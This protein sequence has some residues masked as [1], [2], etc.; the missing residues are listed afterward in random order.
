MNGLPKVAAGSHIS[1]VL[2]PQCMSC[3]TAA[4]NRLGRAFIRRGIVDFV[5]QRPKRVA[6]EDL[7]TDGE[8]FGV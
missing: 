6:F 7:F 5:A 8:L 4:M 1:R 2:E 3:L